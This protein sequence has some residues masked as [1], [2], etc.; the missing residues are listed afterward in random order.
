[1]EMSCVDE[2]ILVSQRW[3][4]VKLI[5]IDTGP[6]IKTTECHGNFNFLLHLSS[7]LNL[8]I[9][10]PPTHYLRISRTKFYL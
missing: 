2:D 7:G 6:D 8:V 1:M 9:I 3:R 5:A 10:S 4:F